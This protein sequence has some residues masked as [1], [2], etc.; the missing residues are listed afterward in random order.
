MS[1]LG[2]PCPVCGCESYSQAGS[3]EPCERC[4]WLKDAVQDCSPRQWGGANLLS[5]NEAR[6]EYALLSSSEAASTVAAA[7]NSYRERYDAVRRSGV[8]RE[9]LA[10]QLRELHREYVGLLE[11]YSQA[12]GDADSSEALK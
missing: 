4:G 1:I 7:K 6:V 8:S 3:Y 12:V 11:K 9:L 10:E 2:K 5:V